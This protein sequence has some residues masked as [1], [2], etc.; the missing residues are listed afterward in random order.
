MAIVLGITTVAKADPDIAPF[1]NH[2]IKELTKSVADDLAAGKLTQT[3]ADELNRAIKHV[4]TEEESEP[5]LT[6]RTRRDMREELSKIDA[7]LRRKE[8]AAKAAASPS[9]TP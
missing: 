7:D 8:A 9:A 1:I 4:Q 2:Q 6:P 5:S 3:D